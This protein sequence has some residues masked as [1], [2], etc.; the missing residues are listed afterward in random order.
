M[1]THIIAAFLLLSAPIAAVA[2]EVVAPPVEPAPAATAPFEDRAEWCD[3]YAS[4]LVAMTP[5]TPAPA[6]VRATRHQ[7]VE[8]NACKIDPQQYERD[9]RAEADAASE[10]A[11]G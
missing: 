4:W 8:L 6:D 5:I 3:S 9:T 1:R 7:E 2:Q 10:V 11:S